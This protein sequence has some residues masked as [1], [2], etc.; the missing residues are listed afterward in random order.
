MVEKVYLDLTHF[1]SYFFT[2]VDNVKTEHVLIQHY[3]YPDYAETIE[4][5]IDSVKNKLKTTPKYDVL[6][7]FTTSL[8]KYIQSNVGKVRYE[9]K[10]IRVLNYIEDEGRLAVELGVYYE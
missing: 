1:R 7:L 8:D 6:S 5:Y 4:K 3:Q 9:F 10:D 2:I